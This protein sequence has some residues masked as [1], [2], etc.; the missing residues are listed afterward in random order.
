MNTGKLL[1]KVVDGAI[2]R[3]AQAELIHLRDYN[4]GGCISCFHCKKTESKHYGR[5]IRND[6]LTPV[7]D[8]AHEA[9]VLV[10]GSP[11]YFSIE[12]SLMR[13]FQE[14]LWFQYYL[15]TNKR[16]PLSPL[17]KATALL[18]TMNVREEEMEKYGKSTV[19]GLAKTVMEHLFAP[20]EL[21]FCTDTMQVE[22]YSKYEMDM[23]DA[24]AK[25]RRHQDIFPLDLER[26]FDM[27]ARL[28][29]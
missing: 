13:A 16:P 26:A 28:V 24:E 5:C 14:R 29:G 27:G 7:L 6:E 18:Y 22:D 17:K 2:S 12:T 8:K 20:C 10:L 25:S 9:E 15:Y 4:Y 11:L 23:W 1:G 3:G 21:F 19:I